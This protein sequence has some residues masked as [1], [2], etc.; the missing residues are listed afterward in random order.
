MWENCLRELLPPIV[1]PFLIVFKIH[2]QDILYFPNND[3]QYLD[4]RQL[5]KY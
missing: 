4:H 1:F 5:K 3:Q 2:T